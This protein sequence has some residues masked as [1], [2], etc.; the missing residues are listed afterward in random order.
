M[1][2]VDQFNDVFFVDVYLSILWFEIINK[3]LNKFICCN[4]VLFV[5]KLYIFDNQL[6][7]VVDIYEGEGII[8]KENFFFG[9]FGMVDRFK[10]L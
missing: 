7:M 4:V 6:L 5:I 2:G 10:F 8:L 3:K 1:S 9:I